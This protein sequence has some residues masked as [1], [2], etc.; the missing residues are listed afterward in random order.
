MKK[1]KYTDFMDALDEYGDAVREF[2]Q[3]DC[4]S[5]LIRHITEN[6]REKMRLAKL[7]CLQIVHEL[8]K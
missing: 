4:A 5:P 1:L 6:D 8:M 2:T 3:K 7:K